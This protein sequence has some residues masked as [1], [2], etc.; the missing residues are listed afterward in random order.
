MPPLAVRW[1]RRLTRTVGRELGD[2]RINRSDRARYG[3][4]TQTALAFG[5][6]NARLDLGEATRPQDQ[7]LRR[8]ER[9]A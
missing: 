5:V 1:A 6:E 8:A 4:D 9:W 7:P 2:D 3:P